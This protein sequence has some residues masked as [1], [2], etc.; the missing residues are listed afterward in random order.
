MSNQQNTK[1]FSA[2]LH[3]LFHSSK[4]T[5]VLFISLAVLTGGLLSASLL[6]SNGGHANAY[7]GRPNIVVFMTDDQTKETMKVM[8]KTKNLLGSRGVT[9]DKN[10]T[11]YNLCCPSRA[12]F[13]TGQYSHNNGVKDNSGPNGG[14]Q[15][16]HNQQTA[17]PAMLR[18][19]G[20][21]TIHIGKYLNETGINNPSEI[22]FGWTDYRGMTGAGTYY[23]Y[24]LNLNG[25]VRNYG[26]TAADYLTDVMK[27]HALNALDQT[28]DSPF[29]LNVGFFGPHYQ[30]EDSE[31]NVQ[32][33]APVPAPR[34][35]GM[36][37]TA[38]MPQAQKPSYLEADVRDKPAHIRR[39][40]RT[41]T[42]LPGVSIQKHYRAELETLESVDDAIEA[43]V[44]NIQ[45]QGKLD[46]TIFIFTSD[47][48]YFHGEHRIP[49]K[50]YFPYEEGINTPLIIAVPN[51]VAQ[52]DNT[53]LVS[54]VDLAPTILDFAG[55]A[56]GRV[57][58]GHSLKA[59]LAGQDQG[60]IRP[61][62]LEGFKNN[63]NNP[64]YVGIRTDRYVYIEYPA[65][66]EKELY[67][68][69]TDPYQVNS[70][71]NNRNYTTIK[72]NLAAKLRT[73]KSCAGASCD[74]R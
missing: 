17:M 45:N 50:K 30:G 27:D 20:Y 15:S 39:R 66:G 21:K 43:V 60:W 29:Y 74:I 70:K 32:A 19:A 51:Q 2:Q 5:L 14:Y 26:S 13:Y 25:Q 36:Y 23:N 6:F 40:T 52:V 33:G 18:N 65:T 46:N 16:Y 63:R 62:L 58:D 73:L 42:A 1:R 57:Q 49:S 41:T 44:T 12:T 7:S 37:A 4:V 9:F 54:N 48:G 24:T 56:A 10:F 72:N 28:G 71:H 31:D 69:N 68:L 38:P 53:H 8:E 22:P 67:D 11:S 64:K 59:L 35:R 61:V 47:N 34:H 55:V 3:K